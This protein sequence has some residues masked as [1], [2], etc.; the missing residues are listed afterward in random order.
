MERLELRPEPL[1][2]VDEARRGRQPERAGVERGEFWAGPGMAERDET[3][4]VHRGPAHR[5]AHE[6]RAEWAADEPAECGVTQRVAVAQVQSR[7]MRQ[8]VFQ[9]GADGTFGSASNWPR[10]KPTPDSTP[11]PGTKAGSSAETADSPA[12]G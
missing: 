4:I 11:V 1:D 9:D 5:E 10:P 2:Q 8:P 12:A 7:Q 3:K 6:P